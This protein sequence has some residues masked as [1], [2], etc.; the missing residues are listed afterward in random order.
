MQFI[1]NRGQLRDKQRGLALVIVMIFLSAITGIS[2]WAVRQSLMGEGM[3]RNQLDLVVARQAAEAALRDAERDIMNVSTAVL[4]NASCSR[5]QEPPLG[6]KGFTELCAQGLC[7]INSDI[8]ATA[9]WSTASAANA[10]PW[11]PTG[12]GGQ[13]NNT[14]PRDQSPVGNC[15]NTSKPNRQPVDTC[16]CNTFTGGVPL[17]T[18]TG[19]T[20]IT[21]VAVQPEYLIE[22]FSR[23]SPISLKP[24]SHYRITARGFGYTPRTQVVLQTVFVPMLD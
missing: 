2:I 12:K 22:Y 1:E 17:G 24:T 5:E 15:T 23:V 16:N 3:A 11:W 20:A 19:A 6:R 13:W 4:P 10:E 14:F 18:Y 7:E 9:S 21:G 8:Y